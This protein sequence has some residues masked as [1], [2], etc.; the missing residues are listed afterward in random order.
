[1]DEEETGA[2]PVE[3]PRFKR[4]IKAIAFAMYYHDFGRR[5][6]GDFAVFST[7]LK[8]R[9]H[10]YR[11]V[12][13]GFENLRYILA[14]S[15]FK[16]MPVPQPKVFKYGISR[17][18]EGQIQYRFEFYEAFFVYALTL[19]HRLSPAIYLP[20]SRDLSVFRLAQE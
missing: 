20:V 16:S 2:F 9:S 5:N 1:M 18:G 11:G 4:V 8:S 10:L 3:L 12:P 13:D 6:E 19:P 14:L 17:P 7:S 15:V